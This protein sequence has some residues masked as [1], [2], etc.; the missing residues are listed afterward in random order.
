VT[1]RSSVPWTCPALLFFSLRLYCLINMILDA[2]VS[3]AVLFVLKCSMVIL[4][5]ILVVIYRGVTVGNSISCVQILTH[6]KTWH[7]C[8]CRIRVRFFYSPRNVLPCFMLWLLMLHWCAHLC[9]I[10]CRCL[11]ALVVVATVRMTM[12]P[13]LL[14]IWSF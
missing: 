13:S 4:Q 1:E 7:I 8:T 12:P 6:F 2:F 5:N 9:C 14:R 11:K 3:F 10:G